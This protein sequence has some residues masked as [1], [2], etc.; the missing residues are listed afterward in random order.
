MKTV[1]YGSL[2]ASLLLLAACETMGTPY[3]G[4]DDVCDEIVDSRKRLDCYESMAQNEDD[5]RAEKKRKQDQ[6]DN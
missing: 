2:A 3:I 5:W 1:I 4:N 6:K